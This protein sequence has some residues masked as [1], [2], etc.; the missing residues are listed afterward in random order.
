M[1]LA[2]PRGE[3][4]PSWNLTLACWSH[5]LSL[6]LLVWVLVANITQVY[7]FWI[8]ERNSKCPNPAIRFLICIVDEDVRSWRRQSILPFLRPP[9]PS[10]VQADNDGTPR[11]SP[12]S[13]RHQISSCFFVVFFSAVPIFDSSSLLHVAF[14]CSL[15]LCPCRFHRRKLFEMLPDVFLMRCLSIFTSSFFIFALSF[16]A[17]SSPTG[18]PM[19]AYLM[20]PM[21]VC[22][23]SFWLWFGDSKDMSFVK[24]ASHAI[25]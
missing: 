9:A 24:S 20:F 11:Q 8:S 2:V 25:L 10:G 23:L 15:A 21:H 3:S 4:L 19:N 1:I 6:M 7:A 12:P 14:W 5:C 17:L 22:F 16:A 13:K 18:G